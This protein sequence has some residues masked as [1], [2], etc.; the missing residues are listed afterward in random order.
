MKKRDLII[1]ISLIIIVGVSGSIGLVFIL[2]QPSQT[3]SRGLPKNWDNAPISASFVL[4][5]GTDFIHVTLGDILEGIQLAIQEE[6][7][8]SGANINEYKDVI[9]YYT[10]YDQALSSYITGVDILDVLEK[11]DTNFA[12][13]ISFESY[14]GGNVSISSGQIIQKMYEGVQDPLIV[15]IAADG[16]WLADSSLG[17]QYGNFSLLGKNWNVQLKNIKEVDVLSNWTVSVMVNGLK[18]YEV[19][20][21][22]MRINEFTANYSYNRSDW[23]N[24]DRQY[25]GR[26]ISEI[27]SLTSASGKNYTIRFYAMDGA[28]SP[29]PMYRAYNRTDVEIGIVPPW[30]DEDK[31]NGTLYTAPVPMPKSN[32]L[33]NLV[34]KDQEFG[35]TGGTVTD[36]IWPY[37]RDCGYHRGPFYVVVPGRPRDAYIKYVYKIEI[38]YTP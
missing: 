34:Y 15:A 2:N 7:D 6:Q 18:E 12:Y 38:S 3:E 5:N 36:P 35:E 1:G 32:L 11:F 30:V 13:N 14:D 25:W 16:K 33:M 23:W 27:V 10:F 37:A 19:N 17:L 31:I 21:S 29:S 26:N 4:N 20:P 28:V 22:N 9:Y 8:T 24:Y